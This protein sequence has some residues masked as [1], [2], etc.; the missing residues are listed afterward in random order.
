MDQ[1]AVIQWRSRDGALPWIAV[2]RTPEEDRW[3]FRERVFKTCQLWGSFGGTQLIGFIA[4]QEN[5]IDHL[6]I[7]PSFQRRG[8]WD[9][10]DSRRTGQAQELSLWTFQRNLVARRFYEQH[11][12]LLV[13]ETDG[14]RNEENEPDALY[15]WRSAS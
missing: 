15:T 5:W 13:D 14:A 7:L 9:D 12:F 10:L 2:L 3:C 1:A 4:F 11:G 8:D 6:Y